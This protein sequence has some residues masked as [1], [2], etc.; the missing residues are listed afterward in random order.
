MNGLGLNAALGQVNKRRSYDLGLMSNQLQNKQLQQQQL[1]EQVNNINK[2]RDSAIN[3][4]KTLVDQA[5]IKGTPR[6]QLKPAIASIVGPIH[7]TLQVAEANGLPVNTKLFQSQ[8]ESILNQ[9]T[10]EQVNQAA[11]SREG[12]IANAKANPIPVASDTSPTGRTYMKPSDAVNQPA[13]APQAPTTNII[14]PAEKIVNEG[15]RRATGVYGEEVGKAAALRDKLA[16]E[17]MNQ[18]V[19][20]DRIKLALERGAITGLGAETVSNLVSMASTLGI[21]VP[22][23]ISESEV[24][25][26]VQGEM[27]L[28]ARNPES[29]L[30]LTGNTSNKDL[31]FLKSV[32]PG[33]QQSKQGNIAIIDLNQRLNKMKMDMSQYQQSV[34]AQNGGSIPLNL[35]SKMME[36]ANNYQFFNKDEKSQLE[37]LANIKENPAPDNVPEDVWNSMTPEEQSLWK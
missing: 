22:E 12:T 29:G 15:E 32:V 24:I 33:L 26:R 21:D 31:S 27:A 2:I 1:D 9:P 37:A 11:A 19:Q 23:N 14:M 28:R 25:R 34:I 3:Q 13:P 4:V 6:D 18:N 7:Q 8:V 35:E 30:G 36:Y 5:D 20:L 17:G 16:T 10:P